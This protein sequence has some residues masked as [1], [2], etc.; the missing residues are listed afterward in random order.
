MNNY[1]KPPTEQLE[2]HDTTYTHM[3]PGQI[4]AYPIFKFIA[5]ESQ[6]IGLQI[7][8]HAPEL[9]TFQICTAARSFS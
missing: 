5:S 7:Q 8:K 3:R 4:S 1:L 9:N 6:F 2:Y